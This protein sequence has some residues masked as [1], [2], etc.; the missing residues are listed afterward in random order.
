MQR[1]ALEREREQRLLREQQEVV[2]ARQL[3]LLAREQQQ[4]REQA[5]AEEAATALKRQEEEEQQQQGVDDA[6]EDEGWEHLTGDAR[7]LFIVCLSPRSHLTL[8]LTPSRIEA[9]VRARL[10]SHKRARAKARAGEREEILRKVGALAPVVDYKQKRVAWGP[11]EAGSGNNSRTAISSP[12]ATKKAT[13]SSTIEAAA[14]SVPEATGRLLRERTFKGPSARALSPSQLRP[15]S[16]QVLSDS[17]PYS[18]PRPNL[19]CSLDV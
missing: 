11:P 14:A 9:E 12:V 2:A 7:C 3:E 6:S 8:N 16:Q 10:R 1:E 18:S 17:S 4:A 5:A 13:A 19:A 15:L